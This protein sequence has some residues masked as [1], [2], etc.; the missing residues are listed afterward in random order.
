[1]GFE[2]YT[3]TPFVKSVVPIIPPGAELSPVS[4]LKPEH[5]GK[6]PG[7][8]R[9]KDKKWRSFAWQHLHKTMRDEQGQLHGP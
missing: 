8:V 6:I 5:L 2:D 9:N 3:G 4:S 1:M 7:W